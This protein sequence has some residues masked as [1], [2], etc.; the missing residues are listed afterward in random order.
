MSTFNITRV[1]VLGA[2][3]MGAQI[4]AHLANAGI[5]VLLYDLAAQTGDPNGVSVNAIKRLQK[6]EPAPLASKEVLTS[7]EPANYDQHLDRLKECEVVIEAIAERM[8][9]K[10]DLYK[11]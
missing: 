6:A 5:S 7:I 8:D 9:W 1:A 3:V 11:K 10:Q 4:A 2:G